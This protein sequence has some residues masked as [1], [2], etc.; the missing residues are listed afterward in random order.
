MKATLGIDIGKRKHHLALLCGTTRRKKA[1]ANTE[2]GFA[3]L[4]TWVEKQQDK[5]G[6][7]EL[8]ICMEA[9]GIYYEAVAEYL[10]HLD[11]PWKLSVVNP[12]RI[13]SYAKSKLKRSKTDSADAALIALFC[14]EQAPGPWQP[15]PVEVKQLQALTRHIE[16]LKQARRDHRNRL[17]SIRDE[18]VRQSMEALIGAIEEQIAQTEQ[19]IEEHVAAHPSLE[20]KQ[21]L[22]CTI[23]GIGFLTAVHLLAE[24]PPALWDSCARKVAAFAGL[25]PRLFESGDSVRRGTRLCKTGS[26]R[27]RRAL[28]MPAVAALRHNSVLRAFAERLL[29]RGK[30]KMAAVGA[31]MRK[32]AHLAFGVL[33]HQQAFDPN[34]T[35]KTAI[36]A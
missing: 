35:Q 29:E 26:A 34:W 15:L 7:D 23:P 33:K 32:L 17:E 31:V 18:Q 19:M 12:A 21:R 22:P 9:T 24:V 27:L 28:Y 5:L 13:A 16:T 6:F 10:Y 3:E 30:H 1:I 8:H 20:E 25:T 2:R 36:P 11:R 14:Q 4:V